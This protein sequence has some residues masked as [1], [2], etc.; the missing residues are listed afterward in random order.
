M[1][2]LAD[3]KSGRSSHLAQLATRSKWI[4]LLGPLTT[5]FKTNAT[6]WKL[7]FDDGETY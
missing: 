4:L 2:S 7:Q 6:G 5:A 1:C 3:S